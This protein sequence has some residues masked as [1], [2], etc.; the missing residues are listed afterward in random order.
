MLQKLM[1]MFGFHTHDSVN[2]RLQRKKLGQWRSDFA[3][4]TWIMKDGKPIKL[5]DMG[6]RHLTN[7]IKLIYRMSAQQK[8]RDDALFLQA[9]APQGDMALMDFEQAA[10]QQF[11]RDT[12]EYAPDIYWSMLEEYK[13]RGLDFQELEAYKQQVELDRFSQGLR[14]MN[15][16]RRS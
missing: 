13:L 2:E 4:E 7:A 5:R 6:H 11:G 3:V 1:L 10:D 9:P 16:S 12:E 14:I 15:A 8:M